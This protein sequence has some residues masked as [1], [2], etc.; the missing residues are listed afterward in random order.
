M[1]W[2]GLNVSPDW[3]QDVFAVQ[4]AAQIDIDMVS[5]NAVLCSLSYR[6]H[7]INSLVFV[8]LLVL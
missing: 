8:S 3:I 7:D 4:S 2:I 6:I 1:L 5:A